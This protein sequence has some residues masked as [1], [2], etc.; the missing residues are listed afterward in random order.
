MQGWVALVSAL[1]LGTVAVPAQQKPTNFSGTW[2]IDLSRSYAAGQNPPV[3]ELTMIIQ[4]DDA[5]LRIETTNNGRKDIVTYLPHAGRTVTANGLPNATFRWDGNRLLTNRLM[6]V[7]SQI[8]EFN[9]IRTLSE[10]G[11]EMNVETT[12]LMHHGYQGNAA[13]LH[14]PTNQSAA[15]NVFVK[16]P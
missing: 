13:P 10:S 14:T 1:L 3:Y 16:R 15:T 11:T 4:Q 6:S 7:N 2:A 9:E 12:L 5:Q 8:L